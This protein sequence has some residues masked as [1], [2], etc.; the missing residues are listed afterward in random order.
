MIT[1][2]TKI[3]VFDCHIDGNQHVNQAR[4]FEFLQSARLDFWLA[5]GKEWFDERKIGCWVAEYAEVKFKRQCVLGDELDIECSWHNLDNGEAWVAQTIKRAG[6]PAV[7]ALCKLVF[8]NTETGRPA[9][10]EGELLEKLRG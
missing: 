7:T 4:Y 2:T 9:K 8:V 1:T 3:R 6:K 5:H 10:L